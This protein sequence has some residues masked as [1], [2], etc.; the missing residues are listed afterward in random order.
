MCKTNPKSCSQKTP[1]GQGKT[2]FPIKQQAF[3]FNS[4]RL[5]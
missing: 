1:F 4:D 2:V 3:T 5:L